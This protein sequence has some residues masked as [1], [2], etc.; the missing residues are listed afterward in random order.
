[1]KHRFVVL[2]RGLE[3]NVYKIAQHLTARLENERG[4]EKIEVFESFP[5]AKEAAL[6]IVSRYGEAS[7]KSTRSFSTKKNP[8]F[9]SLKAQISQLTEDGV[10]TYFL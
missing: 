6:V 1:M 10:E 4:G 2:D 9:D 8:R 3:S 5:D 7:K